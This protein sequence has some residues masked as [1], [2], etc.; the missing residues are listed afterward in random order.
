MTFG[1]LDFNMSCVKTS[2]VILIIPPHQDLKKIGERNGS[3]LDDKKKGYVP[4]PA[5]DQ[6]KYSPGTRQ[7]GDDCRR[8]WF[9]TLLRGNKPNGDNFLMTFDLRGRNNL[10]SDWLM[11]LIFSFSMLCLPA[12]QYLMHWWRTR[13]W[14]S[15]GAALFSIIWTTSPADA[16]CDSPQ[17]ETSNC[18]CRTDVVST[19]L[20]LRV[21]FLSWTCHF[22]HCPVLRFV[23][24]AF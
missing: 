11:T 15:A 20:P 17:Q 8:T 22:E 1:K 5:K 7:H 6:K 4:V 12:D 24:P 19:F 9:L 18:R 10:T 14:I 3:V 23:P 16:H 2:S 13:S 21:F